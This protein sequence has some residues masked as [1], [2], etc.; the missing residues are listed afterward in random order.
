MDRRR[1]F[2]SAVAVRMAPL[3]AGGAALQVNL[4][5]CDSEVRDAFLTGIQTSMTSLIT[6]IINAFF[7]SLQDAGATSQSAVQSTVLNLSGWLA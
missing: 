1:K 5:G 2:W 4:T 3:L 7:L 6:S